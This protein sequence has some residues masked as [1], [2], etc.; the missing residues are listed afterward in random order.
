MMRSSGGTKRVIH[1]FTAAVLAFPTAAG[2]AEPRLPVDLTSH[3]TAQYNVDHTPGGLTLSGTA[4]SQGFYVSPPTATPF[5]VMGIRTATSATR[6]AGTGIVVE[7]RG[8][9]VSGGWTEWRTATADSS[10][11]QLPEYAR[12]VQARITFSGKEHLGKPAVVSLYI[13]PLGSHDPRPERQANLKPFSSRV[14]ATRIGLVGERTANGHVIRRRDRFASLPSRRG[15]NSDDTTNDYVVEICYSRT[16][17]CA[18]APVWDVGP[19]N[20]RDDYWNPPASRE[21]WQDL[22]Q[23]KPQAQAAYADG[24]NQG[25]DERSRKVLNPAGI[26]LANGLFWDDLGMTGNDWVTVTYLWTGS[27]ADDS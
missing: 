13:S 12:S 27:A 4:S 3:E 21:M 25:K 2:T 7:L 24:Y 23:G 6:P 14:Y 26:D 20:L 19:W 8:Q 10:V 11:I 15:L 22:P 1:I 9:S 5:P 18:R 16:N 17:R